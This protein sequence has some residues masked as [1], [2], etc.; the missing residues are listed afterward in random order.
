MDSALTLQVVTWTRALQQ[1]CSRSLHSRW[2][3]DPFGVR[4][5][6]HQR[7]PMH[8]NKMLV[9]TDLLLSDT[10][11]IKAFLHEVVSESIEKKCKSMTHLAFSPPMSNI[12]KQEHDYPK[13]RRMTCIQVFHQ[14]LHFCLQHVHLFHLRHR[15]CASAKKIK[16]SQLN[17]CILASNM[18]SAAL[19]SV[20]E[21]GRM[22]DVITAPRKVAPLHMTARQRK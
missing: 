8:Y 13:P 1:L 20:S 18:K 21:G 11:R 16:T 10:K 12:C 3:H 14:A 17:T 19:L 4:P 6:N 15:H 7:L 5:I 22:R 2:L 9:F